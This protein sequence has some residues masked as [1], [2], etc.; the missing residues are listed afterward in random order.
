M[1]TTHLV[2]INDRA[3]LSWVL[4]EQR[5]AFPAH[6]AH[7]VHA[8]KPGDEVLLYTTRGCFRSPTHDFGRVIGHATVSSPV[9]ALDEPVVFRERHFTEGCE[10][11]IHGL[12]PF[13]TGLVLRD[14]VH[15]LS[16]FPD[17]K[18]W[19][20][21]MRRATLPLSPNDTMLILTKLRPYLTPY[22][23]AVSAYRWPAR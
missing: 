23:D 21:R 2:I 10:F 1:P 16:V 6:R 9:R 18:T 4:S 19:S 14:H 17:P 5:M 22:A 8:I 12:A 20:I 3:A 13:R 15:Q 11:T 7:A